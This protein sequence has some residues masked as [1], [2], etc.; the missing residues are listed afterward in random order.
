MA[1]RARDLSGP[2]LQ[3]H[4]P[5]KRWKERKGLTCQCHGKLPQ[6][7]HPS[8]T[9]DL[10]PI[11]EMPN[12]QIFKNRRN[13]REESIQQRS[14][15]S[16]LRCSSTLQQKKT[17]K[18]VVNYLPLRDHKL[19][20]KTTTRFLALETIVCTRC[21]PAKRSETPTVRYMLLVWLYLL[22]TTRRLETPMG[23]LFELIVLLVWIVGFVAYVV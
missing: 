14:S 2:T 16:P 22:W 10:S 15:Q 18:V 3:K 20:I 5:R 13:A 12:P 11:C 9:S 23:Q 1:K 17:M 21:R 19:Q 8:N 7:H 6:N 4:L